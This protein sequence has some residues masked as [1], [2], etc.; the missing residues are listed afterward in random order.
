MTTS[1][2]PSTNVYAAIMHDIRTTPPARPRRLSV[3]A[4]VPD[5]ERPPTPATPA[6]PGPTLPGEDERRA[7]FLADYAA[8]FRPT[9]TRTV[10]DPNALRPY[11]RA[12]LQRLAAAQGHVVPIDLLADSLR[13]TRGYLMSTIVYELRIRLR[14]MTGD[15]DAAKCIVTVKNPG[16][17][18]LDLEAAARYPVIVAALE[19]GTP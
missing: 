19:D 2:H 5:D 14:T 17:Y 1:F 8:A 13:L 12:I 4:L 16:G 3:F 9:Q 7:A 10:D 15:P 11:E 6:T 18:Y